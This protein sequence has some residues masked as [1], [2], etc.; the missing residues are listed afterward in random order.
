MKYPYDR[1]N[2][3]YL[4]DISSEGTAFRLVNLQNTVH[5]G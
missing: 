5:Y 1:T 2:I 4:F 3:L